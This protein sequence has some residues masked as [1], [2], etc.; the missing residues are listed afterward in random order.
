M[1]FIELL[2]IALGLSMDAFTVAICQGLRMPQMRYRQAAVVGIYFGAFQV[3][4]PTIGWLMGVS[5][6]SYIE[7]C[8]HW[9]AFVLLVF[10]GGKM[11]WDTFMDTSDEATALQ[12]YLHHK[13]LLLLAIATSID[14]LAV[15]VEF[16][17]LEVEILPS[18]LWIGFVTFVLSFLGV[19]IGYHFGNH[20]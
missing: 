20:F 6:I 12:S 15:G 10:L 4:M 1:G 18:I 7:S 19:I 8:D 9:I 13:D 11:I 14:A 17:C 16:A 5:F 3:I 2:C